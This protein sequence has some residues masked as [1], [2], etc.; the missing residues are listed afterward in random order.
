ME[1]ISRED[2]EF[3]RDLGELNTLMIARNSSY[4]FELRKIVMEKMKGILGGKQS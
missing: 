2:A 3:T 4:S 1:T